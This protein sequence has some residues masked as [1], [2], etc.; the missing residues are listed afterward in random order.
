VYGT[1]CFTGALAGA[2]TLPEFSPFLIPTGVRLTSYAG[3]AKDLPAPVFQQQLDA[4]ADG[5]LKAPVAKVYHG[6]EQVRDAHA[7]IEAG[8]SPG[9]HV[10]LLDN[11]ERT[12]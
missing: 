1:V 7:A 2:W 12:E 3:G 8:T 10:V 9:K 5:R 11:P 6:L 4:I